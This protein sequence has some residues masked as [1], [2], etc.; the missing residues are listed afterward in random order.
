MQSILKH[1]TLV[2]RETYVLEEQAFHISHWDVGRNMLTCSVSSRIS[3]NQGVGLVLERTPDWQKVNRLHV[4]GSN[5]RTF[6]QT[7][8]IYCTKWLPRFSSENIMQYLCCLTSFSKLE[9]S[10]LGFTVLVLGQNTRDNYHCVVK[11]YNRICCVT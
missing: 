11:Y 10:F 7:L 1:I 8:H 2:R 5:M 6:A 9:I 3:D 4:Y